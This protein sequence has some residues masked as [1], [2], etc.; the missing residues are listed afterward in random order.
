MK[1]L[2]SFKTSPECFAV[3]EDVE[4]F[5]KTLNDEHLSSDG[6]GAEPEL[7]NGDE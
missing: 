7:D 1:N 6:V 2:A 4:Q 3:D 5:N